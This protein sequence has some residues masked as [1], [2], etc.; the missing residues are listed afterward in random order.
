MSAEGRSLA[1]LNPAQ[2]LHASCIVVRDSGVLIRGPSG[3]G[4]SSLA[5]LLLAQARLRGEFAAWVA[6]DRV[7]VTSSAGRLLAAPHPRIAGRFEARGFGLLDEPHEPRA[8][9]RL[10]LD[11]EEAVERL[12]AQSELSALVAGVALRRM[13]LVARRAGLYEASL[14]LS[15]VWV[16]SVDLDL[17]QTRQEGDSSLTST[18]RVG[19]VG[20]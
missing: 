6:D 16:S 3:A 2:T 14:V 20:I 15:E 11:L 19:A 1:R 4:K 12:P 8:V 18:S 17:M 13:P 5:T 10:V 9:L 7:V